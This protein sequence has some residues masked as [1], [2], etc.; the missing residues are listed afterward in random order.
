MAERT[1]VF[2]YDRSV[3]YLQAVH[4]VSG[5]IARRIVTEFGDDIGLRSLMS[6]M[7]NLELYEFLD[8]WKSQCRTTISEAIALAGTSK[9]ILLIEDLNIYI[10]LDTEGYKYII[11]CLREYYAEKDLPTPTSNIYQLVSSNK[12]HQLVF[13]TRSPDGPGIM[14]IMNQLDI[15]YKVE[16]CADYRAYKTDKLYANY[17]ESSVAYETIVKKLPDIDFWREKTICHSETEMVIKHFV[18]MITDLTTIVDRLIINPTV[19]NIT[20]TAR[21]NNTILVGAGNTNDTKQKKPTD[22]I[23]FLT[24]WMINNPPIDGELKEDYKTRVDNG[25]KKVDNNTYG[26][27]LKQAG[28]VNYRKP[29]IDGMRKR[30]FVIG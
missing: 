7:E 26:F 21:D 20:V 12:Q 16:K 10:V 29:T 18:G 8:I 3:K 2:S 6:I 28:F 25:Y 22:K 13:F 14:R 5:Q 17:D 15:G 24:Q 23:K 9:I 11:E 19:Q 30:M 27:A 1:T 4:G